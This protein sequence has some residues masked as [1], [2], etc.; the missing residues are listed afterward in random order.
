[1]LVAMREIRS[2]ARCLIS[3]MVL[4]LGASCTAPILVTT[5]RPNW[6]QGQVRRDS[7]VDLLTDLK[8]LQEEVPDG[9][10]RVRQRYNFLVSRVV[11]SVNAQRLE[12]W[13]SA[14]TLN[15]PRDSYRLTAC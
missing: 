4:L 1:M 7:L 6:P 8:T 11:E 12:P 5:K 14:V 3:V 15:G 2:M 9:D 10:E 13:R